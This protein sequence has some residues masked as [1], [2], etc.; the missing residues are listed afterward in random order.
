MNISL[1]GINTIHYKALLSSLVPLIYVTT[2][3]L[4]RFAT[5]QKYRAPSFQ[6]V[7]I[8]KVIR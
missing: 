4:F 2:T 1:I 8:P 3:V 7:L 6:K 5:I